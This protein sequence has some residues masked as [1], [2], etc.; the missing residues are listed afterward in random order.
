MIQLAQWP[1]SSKFPSVSFPLAQ[2]LQQLTTQTDFH[3]CHFEDSGRETS[4]TPVSTHTHSERL[5]SHICLA[6][7][8]HARLI[9]A[10]WASVGNVIEKL[11]FWGSSSRQWTAERQKDCTQPSW[12]C[13]LG[14]DK[15]CIDEDESTE[16]QGILWV[17]WVSTVGETH[18]E[19]ELSNASRSMWHVVKD[20]K[21]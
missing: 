8:L 11:S 10:Q 4:R 20:K 19:G 3:N 14:G 21:Y 6:C 16:E 9:S 13:M 7:L 1:V 15:Y 2:G 12:L 5:Y 17:L 18:G